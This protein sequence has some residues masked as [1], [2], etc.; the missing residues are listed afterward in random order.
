MIL[1]EKYFSDRL[2]L[3]TL[4]GPCLTFPAFEFRFAL[5][6]RFSLNSM[7]NLRQRYLGSFVGAAVM[8]AF[9]APFEFTPR[10]ASGLVHDMTGGGVHRLLPGFWTDD[11]SMA[12]CLAYSILQSRQFDPE[13]QMIRYLRWMDEGYLSS[14]GECFDV[15][16]QTREA[17]DLFRTTGKVYAGSSDDAK[18]GNGSIMRL[19]PIPLAYFRHPDEAVL[20]AVMSSRTTHGSIQCVEACRYLCFLVIEALRGV[21]KRIFL[22]ADRYRSQRQGTVELPQPLERIINGSYADLSADAVR[23]SGW[24]MHT[25]EAA[26]WAFYHTDSFE[27]GAL[28]IPPL[29][30][31]T[32]TVGAVYG[33]LAGAYYGFEAIPDRWLS[34]LAHLPMLKA[35]ADDLY[36]FANP[37]VRV[38]GQIERACHLSLSARKDLAD[39]LLELVASDAPQNALEYAFS[40]LDVLTSG[41]APN[42]I[43]PRRMSPLR[44]GLEAR[45]SS[46]PA[47][48]QACRKFS[49][50]VMK[51]VR[52]QLGLL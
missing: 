8:D 28:L 37:E 10:G 14:T 5:T 32:D 41:D 46:S 49:S 44:G 21:D 31:D 25:L 2:I 34:A 16:I 42:G 7:V 52:E 20:R 12:L 50:Q 6:I 3:K 38:L 24:V 43:N 45:A 51:V 18:S 4:F 27:Q 13:D 29:G 48:I 35:C 33:Q 30:D 23:T 26:L 11:T 17:L 9:C 47:M 19:S 40:A 1:S 22:D 39:A 15:G 36:H